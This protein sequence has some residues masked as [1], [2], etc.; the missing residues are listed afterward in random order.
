MDAALAQLCRLHGILT[1]ALDGQPAPSP[2]TAIALLAAMGVRADS[3]AAV[4]AALREH[5]TRRWRQVLSPVRVALAGAPLAIDLCWPRAQAQATL[6]WVI[7]AESGALH[8]GSLV[9]ARLPAV[10]AGRVGRSRYTRYRF[11]LPLELPPGYHRLRLESGEAEET[12]ATRLI[13]VPSRCYR[14]PALTE[15][16]RL[17]GPG[18]RLISVR[19]ARNWGTGDFTDLTRLTEFWGGVG[20]G[21]VDIGPLADGTDPAAAPGAPRGPSARPDL[22]VLH[23]DLEAMA[24]FAECPAAQEL[25]RGPDFQAQLRAFRTAAHVPADAITAAKYRVLELL[26]RGFRER[27]LEPGSGRA[28]GFRAYQRQGGE[29]LWRQS[30]FAALAEAR[31]TQDP[32][33]QDPDAL[34]WSDW[35]AAWRD[36][37]SPEVAAFAAAHRER[38]E[39]FQYLHWQAEQQLGVAGRRSWEL[40]LGVGIV[41][42]LS[43]GAA[44]QDAAV[45]AAPELYATGVHLGA[46]TTAANPDGTHWPWVPIPPR[47]LQAAGYAPWSAILARTMRVPGALRIDP[48]GALQAQFWVPHGAPPAAGAWVRYPCRALL[49]VLALESHRNRCLVIGADPQAGSRRLG[50]RLRAS[51]L[52]AYRVACRS[53]AAP[54]T[55]PPAPDGPAEPSLVA[56]T[57]PPHPTLD[58]YWAGSDLA[59]VT[60]RSATPTE[61]PTEPQPEPSAESPAESP[62][63]SQAEPPAESQA[64]QVV[65]RAGDRARL[66]LA[67]AQQGLLPAGATVHAVSVPAMTPDLVHAI[68]CLLGRSPAPLITL[69]LADLLGPAAPPAGAEP[70]G[71]QRLAL[72]LER[73]AE[74]P[75]LRATA[76]AL[77]QER[78]PGAR[79]RRG[80]ELAEPMLPAVILEGAPDQ[81]PASP[82]EPAA[83]VVPRATYRLQIHQGFTFDDALARVPYLADLGISHCYLS[84]ILRARPGS[85][86]GY[87]II[88]HGT[89]N[90]ELGGLAGFERLAAALRDRGMGLILDLVPNHMGIMGGDNAWWL[91]VLENGP[92]AAAAA[93]F[94]IDWQ[95]LKDE[96]R[97]KVLVPTLGDHYGNVLDRGELRLT[98][99]P[100]QGAFELRYFEHRFPVDPR[101]YPLILAPGS[102]RLE[103]RLGADDPLYL[104]FTSLITACT[105]L[106][107]RSVTDPAERQE[108]QRDAALCKGHLARLAQSSADLA[109]YLD[110]CLREYNGGADYPAD[111]ERLHRLLEAQAYRPAFWRVAADEINYRRFFDINDLASL[112]MDEPEVFAASHRLVLD[113]VHRGLVDGLR[114][115][116]A[117]GLYDPRQYF[118]R[119][120]AAIADGAAGAGTAGPRSLWVVVEKILA[121]HERLREDWPVHGTTGYDFT[122]L[123]GG[124]LVEARAGRSLERIYRGY[125][126][127]ARDLEALIYE[128][129]RLIMKSTLASE[130]NVLANQ[131]ARIA[132]S[133]RH[134]RDYTLNGLRSALAEVVACFPVYRT[135]VTADGA[136]PEDVRHVER[137]VAAARRRSLA[138]DTSVFDFIQDVLLL[139]AGA[140]KGTVYASA[141]AAFALKFQQYT[142]PVQAK[143]IEDTA[144]YRYHRLCSLN[145]V[146]SDPRRCGVSL[147]TFHRANLE[148][149]RRWPHAMLATSTHDSKRA[150]DLRAR[151]HALSELPEVWQAHLRR[152]QRINRSLNRIVDGEP[153]PSRNEEY[154]LYQTL[155]GTWPWEALD[156]P[157]PAGYPER[158]QAYMLKAMREAKD[159]TSWL[160]NHR[161]YEDA[162]AAFIAGLLDA[163]PRSQAFLADFLPFEARIARL[164]RLNSLTQ[165]LL[166]LTV[167][168]VPDLYQGCEFWDLSLVD[169]DNRRPVD[170]AAR[171]HALLEL[172]E[173]DPAG[174]SPASA[175]GVGALLG[176]VDP[177][178]IK[179][180]VIRQCLALR[181]RQPEW[182]ARGGYRPLP[183]RGP[184]ARHVVAFARTAGPGGL[185]VVAGRLYAALTDGGRTWPSGEVWDDTRV[186]L[187]G[188]DGAW[189]NLLTGERVLV[190]S[191]DTGPV[192]ALRQ[193]FATLPLALLTSPGERRI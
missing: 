124:L 187:T 128:S 10:D 83:P 175:A 177:G 189:Q 103:A 60:A 85:T 165:T 20:A 44:A 52:Y 56:F 70:P 40:G 123:C 163:G 102:A 84:P 82:P 151:L 174:A 6:A 74:D 149:A 127:E 62:G 95:P 88:D 11:S 114:I 168:G 50:A 58:A 1:R 172:P 93:Y 169:P 37:R 98:F 59:G 182:F 181:R 73:W 46:P 5:Q 47:R 162:V 3:P 156:G 150:E 45:W 21:L 134:T 30:V 51:G 178:V 155:V 193:L 77:R 9:P 133:D 43:L 100:A 57:A 69:N 97:G 71:P 148:R 109:W 173:A 105:H 113:L 19:S 89:I 101:E 192:I 126:G 164:G 147:S 41:A 111:R 136:A 94:D 117:D 145:E 152:W 116:H 167:P 12:A 170:W 42:E 8:E 54:L 91:D 92:A 125:L 87:D 137:A 135:Y 79:P 160:N 171:E 17:W 158:I 120:Q 24:D 119:L 76:E 48:L 142:A 4:R 66:L 53:G 65:S 49:G 27:H 186:E 34:H 154:L 31:R 15:G 67:L 86:H 96:L 13:L 132:G 190:S 72:D 144:C 64:E 191:G 141:V 110:E 33:A 146:G 106:P 159:H 32:G 29:S 118:C 68:H 26:Y 61:P 139:R 179:L 81:T 130:L 140:G 16:A 36:P 28:K 63:E 75:G 121:P 25:V 185:V 22:D 138:A 38:V 166:K 112:R 2:T 107:P 108:R 7:E 180:H 122:A 80:A 131:L 14:P 55:L 161:A 184:R 104:E 23:L 18:T 143:G 188:S 78:G 90:P 129:K 115:D 157:L 35:P 99:D 153:A 176:Q 183:V 39:F